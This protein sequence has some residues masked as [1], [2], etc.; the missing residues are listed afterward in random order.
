MC[1]LSRCFLYTQDNF[2]LTTMINSNHQPNGHEP[3]ALTS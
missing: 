3:Y 2:V 1:V